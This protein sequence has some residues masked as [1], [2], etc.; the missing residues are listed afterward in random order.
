[1]I[2]KQNRDVRRY[3]ATCQKLFYQLQKKPSIGPGRRLICGF[4]F[5]RSPNSQ[6]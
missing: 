1:V 4:H 2:R 6:L 5:Q 3:G